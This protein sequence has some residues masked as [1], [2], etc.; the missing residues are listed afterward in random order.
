MIEKVLEWQLTE[1]TLDCDD[2]G[3]VV[4]I[5]VYCDGSMKCTGHKK[6]TENLTKR[7]AKELKL[8][9]KE[10]GKE[11]KCKGPDCSRMLDYKNFVFSGE[12]RSR[13]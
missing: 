7:R 1:S 12:K 4:T 5:T 11:L 8:R 6:Y 13:P 3:T 2:V 9:G 10:L